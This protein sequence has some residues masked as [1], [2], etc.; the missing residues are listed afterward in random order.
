MS[1][2]GLNALHVAWLQAF[3]RWLALKTERPSGAQ[4]SSDATSSKHCFEDTWQRSGITPGAGVHVSTFW[5][6]VAM[7]YSTFQLEAAIT[8]SDKQALAN[9]LKTRSLKRWPSPVPSE[10]N[11]AWAL[12]LTTCE[13]VF[14]GRLGLRILNCNEALLDKIVAKFWSPNME[15]AREQQLLAQ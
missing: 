3:S 13:E 4:A 1:Y 8:P 14:D 2:Q 15:N 10:L 6:V 7:R 5:S 12:L 11:E 9:R